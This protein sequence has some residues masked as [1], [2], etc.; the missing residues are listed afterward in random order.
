[1]TMKLFGKK[2]NGG[3]AK[4][5][6]ILEEM[7][8]T[9]AKMNEQMQAQNLQMKTLMQKQH[10]SMTGLMR[11]LGSSDEEETAGN[12]NKEPIE[13]GSFEITHKN[14]NW[15]VAGYTSV[16]PDPDFDY[17]P[18]LN[19]RPATSFTIT[20]GSES[21]GDDEDKEQQPPPP[22]ESPVT[23]TSNVLSDKIISAIIPCY[24]EDGTDLDRTIRGL[25][26]QIMPK[27]WH[28]ELVIVM[29]GVEA[30]SDSMAKYLAEKFG[31]VFKSGDKETDPFELFPNAQTIVIHPVSVSAGKTRVP[32]MDNTTGGF[33]LVVKRKNK[34]K[35]NSQM[36]W[37]GPHATAIGCKYSLATDC[38][39]Y[40]ERMTTSR[41]ID[42]LD[43]EINTHAV[44]GFQRTMPS[45]IQ[46]DG[47]FEACTH[48]FH[49]ML[50]NLQRFEF[51][52]DHVSFMNIYDTLG[53][54]HVVSMNFD[55]GV[56]RIL[57]DIDINIATFF[58]TSIS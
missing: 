15:H 42:R 5:S 27:G 43:A 28:V 57:V 38:G 54:M 6:L 56:V 14:T 20:D 51:E 52:V 49:S 53:A 11:R 21:S 3:A 4:E 30:M 46:G 35:A 44:T 29:D 36:W 12:E 8:E 9:M 16:I 13:C 1:M 33:S 48:P 26:R 7:K 22:A 2:R 17:F 55:L 34:R 23:G 39:T 19:K 47:N 31:V 18:G 32:V 37:L 24:N 10:D 25:S 40:F 50:R 41:L 45:D 58:C